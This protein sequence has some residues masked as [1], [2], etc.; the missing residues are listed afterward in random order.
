MNEI[1]TSGIK[2]S[3]E[4]SCKIFFNILDLKDNSDE[5]KNNCMDISSNKL[6]KLHTRRHRYGCK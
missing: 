4:P 3:V 5:K 6:A 1:S 2:A